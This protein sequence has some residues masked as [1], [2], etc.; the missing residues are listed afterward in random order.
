M[1]LAE[2]QKC[3]AG[4][5]QRSE[6]LD[7]RFLVFGVIFRLRVVRVKMVDDE[8]SDFERQV[9]YQRKHAVNCIQA[10][11]MFRGAI[12]V[13]TLNYD[14]LARLDHDDMGRFGG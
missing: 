9:I 10:I 14:V 11:D 4:Q 8:S 12:V 13:E 1:F 5:R 2:G 6:A 3:L 7:G